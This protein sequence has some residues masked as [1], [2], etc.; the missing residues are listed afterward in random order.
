MQM[1]AAARY[2]ATRSASRGFLPMPLTAFETPSA[3]MEKVLLVTVGAP[4]ED[5]DRILEHV[6]RIVPLAQGPSYDSNSYESPAGFE[7][8]RP[9]SGAVAGTEAAVRKRPGIVTLTF[10]LENDPAMLAEVVETVFQV[11]SYQEPVIRISETLTC[12]SKG[13][14]DRNNPYRWWNTSGDWK[15]QPDQS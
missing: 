5:V 3:R 14:D 13:L 8:Y 7:R 1:S 12:R 2:K 6:C 9:R 10:E 15:A 4:Q 11:H